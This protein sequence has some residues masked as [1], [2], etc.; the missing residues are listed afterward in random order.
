MF[1]INRQELQKKGRH[2]VHQLV[3][4]K[5]YASPLDLFL[6]MGKISPKLVEDWRFGKVPYLERV[7]HDKKGE[8]IA[9]REVSI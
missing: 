6:E 3:W 9:P 4:K 8:S 2:T 7:L 1:R 5:G